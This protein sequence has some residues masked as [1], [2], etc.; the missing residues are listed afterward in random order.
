MST[1][2]SIRTTTKSTVIVDGEQHVCSMSLFSTEKSGSFKYQMDDIKASSSMELLDDGSQRLETKISGSLGNYQTKFEGDIMGI[3]PSVYVSFDTDGE[4]I[5][6][7]LP[8]LL[9]GLATRVFGI[10][11]RIFKTKLQSLAFRLLRSATIYV[12]LGATQGLSGSSKING[13]SCMFSV[14]HTGGSFQIPVG[15]VMDFIANPTDLDG[16]AEILAPHIGIEGLSFELGKGKD[17]IKDSLT[18]G[19][20]DWDDLCVESDGTHEWV[21]VSEIDPALDI[22]PIC[23]K[24][25]EVIDSLK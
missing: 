14:G 20:L 22:K 25:Q 2:N 1:I 16:L 8:S 15:K 17:K 23:G 10:V 21:K 4:R 19:S 18:C 5:L 24:I 11:T 3:K 12:D 7:H 6:S 13:E 9:R